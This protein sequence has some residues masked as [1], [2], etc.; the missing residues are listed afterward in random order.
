[1]APTLPQAVRGR[2]WLVCNDAAICVRGDLV[3]G[4]ARAGPS[5][6]RAGQAN[7]SPSDGSSGVWYR[8]LSHPQVNDLPVEPRQEEVPVT[9]TLDF[10]LVKIVF[11]P[12]QQHIWSM[13]V[14]LAILSRCPRKSLLE[15]C[16]P[17]IRANGFL[18]STESLFQR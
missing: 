13:I 1:M 4:S 3:R 15:R 5:V 6:I 17:S 10:S 18:L 14:P 2:N 8:R 7:I 9:L 12:E 16:S 11:L